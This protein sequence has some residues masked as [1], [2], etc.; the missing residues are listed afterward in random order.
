MALVDYKGRL[1]PN[2]KAVMVGGCWLNGR[3]KDPLE[4]VA[5]AAPG[6][7]AKLKSEGRFTQG[8]SGL[9]FGGKSV[10]AS[11]TTHDKGGALDIVTGQKGPYP[12]L[13]DT[14]VRSLVKAF[15]DAGFAAPFRI[16][17]YDLGT[18][19]NK[20]EHIH[21]VLKGFGN[22][23]ACYAATRKGGNAHIDKMIAKR[24]GG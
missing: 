21:A 7:W 14:Y 10:T 15:E 11:G 24:Y 19:V 9:A 16:V 6:L 23:R 5:S 1:A 2:P 12:P 20:T 3:L 4:K 8:Y 17:G 13:L 18:A 22:Y